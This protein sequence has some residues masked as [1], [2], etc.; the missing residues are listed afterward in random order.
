MSQPLVLCYHAVSERWPAA[1]SVTPTALESQLRFLVDRGYR[2]T[3]FSEA[4]AG[5]PSG[6]TVVV[7]F[8]DSYRSVL[9]QAKPILDRL[10]LVGTVFVPT[11]FAGKQDPMRWDGIDQWLEGQYREELT[12]MDWGE[13]RE[14]TSCDWEVGSHTCTHPRL[15]AIDDEALDQELR[16]SRAV[17][18]SHLE[19]P[20]RS[21][22]YPYGDHDDR[23]VRA[24][25]AA[26]YTAAATLPERLDRPTPLRWPRVGIY[27]V[28]SQREFRLKVSPLVRR[29]R[30]SAL[31]RPAYKVRQALR[32][33]A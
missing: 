26:G 14:L 18:E 10:G 32:T 9:T 1:L 19:E 17:L 13:L 23:V 29:L 31:A 25:E 27:H 28:D 16:D 6:K 24:T 12:P 15:T 11:S 33:S 5:R 4:V 3:T 8:D 21:I 7:T 22:A 20:C 30:S 2:G